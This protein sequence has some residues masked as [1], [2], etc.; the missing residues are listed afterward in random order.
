MMCLHLAFEKSADG[1]LKRVVK[2]LAG[3][4]VHVDMIVTQKDPIVM[5]TSYSAH[6]ARTFTSKGPEEYRFDDASYDFLHVPADLEE[7]RRVMDTCDACVAVRMPYNG[8]DMLLSCVPMRSPDEIDI[9]HCK[10]LYCAQAMVL[11]LRACLNA[12][13]PLQLVLASVNSRT[14]TPTE[15]YTRLVQAGVCRPRACAKIMCLD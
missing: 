11:I 14:V 7:C 1:V 6:L 5:H 2:A 8:N 10:S 13:H 4:Y 12:R 3:P 9:Y 15:L